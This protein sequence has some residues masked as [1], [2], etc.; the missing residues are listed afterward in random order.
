MYSSH[1]CWCML[2]CCYT[3]VSH[4]RDMA[5]THGCIQPASASVRV[6]LFRSH[7]C[8]AHMCIAS[9]HTTCVHDMSC[10]VSHGSAYP[11]SYRHSH[12]SHAHRHHTHACVP[13]SCSC[14]LHWASFRCGH[15]SH[16][17]HPIT[18]VMQHVISTHHTSSYRHI[19]SGAPVSYA[20]S[21]Q[22]S[23]GIVCCATYMPHHC[24]THG[25]P[26]TTHH[27]VSHSSGSSVCACL[28]WH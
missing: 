8:H 27:T 5:C 17:C 10:H 9:H 21:S 15:A 2:R 13:C 23:H 7:S 24:P 26:R 18:H 14:S 1:C 19:A 16:A 20:H 25:T 3:S 4:V 11:S 28:C 22:A 12:S 6:W